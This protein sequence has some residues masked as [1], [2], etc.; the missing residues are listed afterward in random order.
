M[1]TLNPT[2]VGAFLWDNL[3]H[4]FNRAKDKYM[5]LSYETIDNILLRLPLIKREKEVITQEVVKADA[6]IFKDRE[7]FVAFFE[8]N[9]KINH[10]LEGCKNI[11]IHLEDGIGY[12]EITDGDIIF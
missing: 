6:T 10:A 4:F 11:K 3:G 7:K 5:E 8:N 1:E 9:E 2:F 12:I